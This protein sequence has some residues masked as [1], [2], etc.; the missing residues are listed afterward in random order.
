[1]TFDR[2]L[3]SAIAVI[4]LI[5]SAGATDRYDVIAGLNWGANSALVQSQLQDV[6]D[7]IKVVDADPVQFPL[8]SRSE[9]HFL[10]K[11]LG[12]S[13][14]TIASAAFVVADDQLKMIEARGGAVSALIE[15]RDDEAME[16]LK[17]QVFE[18]GGIFSS[19]EADTVWFLSKEAL[20]P[21]LFTWSNP[22]L[23]EP[24]AATPVYEE[25]AALPDLLEFGTDVEILKPKFEAAC[26]IM[27]IEEIENVWL[28]NKPAK[29]IQINCFGYDYAGFPRK[30]E[31][32][33][34]DGVLELVWILTGKQEENRVR[35]ALIE[36]F[37]LAEHVSED[38]EVFAGGKVSLRKDKPEIL[39]ISEKLVPFYTEQTRGE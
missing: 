14:D 25:S 1:M 22:F 13:T 7:D 39:A 4:A 19:A 23:D 28:P 3:Y 29:Q 12:L 6:C 16:Y 30:F 5:E 20:H 27:N 24:D 9:K 17:Y 11:G 35:D 15:S 37:G 21:N 36:A 38:W 10:C 34:G 32:V 8:A 26:P 2:V 33:F 18:Q 31:A